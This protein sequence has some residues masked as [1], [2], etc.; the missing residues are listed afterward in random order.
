MTE[1]QVDIRHRHPSLCTQ[2]LGTVNSASYWSPVSQLNEL[3][4]KRHQ[5]SPDPW[6]RQH[7]RHQTH[8]IR[9]VDN[10]PP[11]L[12]TPANLVSAYYDLE[13]KMKH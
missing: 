8:L 7:Q 12:L 10:N 13:E 2:H 5:Y 9:G 11:R 6:C 3:I 1:A 4:A